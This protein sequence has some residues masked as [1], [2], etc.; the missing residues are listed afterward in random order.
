MNHLGNAFQFLVLKIFFDGPFKMFIELVYTIVSLICFVAFFFFFGPG[1]MWDLAATRPG[2]EP[3][4][5]ALEGEVLNHDHQGN[6]L[7]VSFVSSQGVY[8]NCKQI[9]MFLNLN[10]FGLQADHCTHHAPSLFKFTN[11]SFSSFFFS[12]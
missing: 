5:S 7:L 4:P 9:C 10:L 3:E 1:G 12:L 2:I 11:P 6:L 8:S